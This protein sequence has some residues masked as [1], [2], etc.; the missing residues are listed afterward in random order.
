MQNKLVRCA[1]KGPMCNMKLYKLQS[2]KKTSPIPNYSSWEK[3]N[4]P[5][6]EPAFGLFALGYRTNVNAA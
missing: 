1:V 3:H 6:L 4:K 2:G 5:A